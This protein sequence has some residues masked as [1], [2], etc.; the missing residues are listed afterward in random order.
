VNSYDRFVRVILPVGTAS[1]LLTLTA[2][3]WVTQPGRFVRGYAPEQPVAYSHRLHA[4]TM[5]IPCQ[6][7]HSNASRSRHAGVPAVET[8]M[9]CH[10]VTKTESASI[11]MLTAIYESGRSLKWKRIHA[12]PDHVY[13]DHRPH[14]NAGIACQT[15]H[16]EIQ[17]LDVVSQHMSMRMGN[18]LGCHRDAHAALP[19]QSEVERGAEYCNACHR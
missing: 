8:C 17:T 16:G 2:V 11:Q 13:F 7:C 9:N 4:G 5:K 10:R 14:V 3:G 19:A 12:L 6:Y 18:C 1:L 15:C